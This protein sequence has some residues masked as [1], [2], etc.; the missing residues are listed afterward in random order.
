[1]TVCHLTA[2]RFLDVAYIA[3]ML[4]MVSASDTLQW[5]YV[6]FNSHDKKSEQAYSAVGSC[7]VL[8]LWTCKSAN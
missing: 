1:M 5:L 8:A 2:F 3:E 4:I 6:D 7:V